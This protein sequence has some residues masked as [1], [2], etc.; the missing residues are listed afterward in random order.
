LS[1]EVWRAYSPPGTNQATTTAVPIIQVYDTLI[2]PWLCAC[3]PPVAPAGQFG[4]DLLG[5]SN[6][7]Y[8]IEYSPDL[9]N[10]TAIATN[11]D[12]VPRRAFSVPGTNSAGFFQAVVPP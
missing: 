10:W 1:A 7:T 4:F 9:T 8:V 12:I 2:Q 3:L 5:Q 11:Y 6:V